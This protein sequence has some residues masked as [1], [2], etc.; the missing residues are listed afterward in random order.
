[1]RIPTLILLL[2]SLAAPAKEVE[3]TSTP[4][5]DWQQPIWKNVTFDAKVINVKDIPGAKADAHNT[6]FLLFS[7]TA[8][9]KLRKHILWLSAEITFS[10]SKTTLYKDIPIRINK[11]GTEHTIEKIPTQITDGMEKPAALTVTKIHITEV[12]MK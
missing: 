11:A 12:T 6:D 2:L 8:K 1:M 7:C 4:L 9:E 10:N 3:V 5:P